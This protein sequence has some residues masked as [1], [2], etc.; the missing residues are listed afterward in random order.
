MTVT[1]HLMEEQTLEDRRTMHRLAAVIGAFGVATAI[2]AI[3]V[4]IVMG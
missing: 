4:A 1:Q 3:V 2:M